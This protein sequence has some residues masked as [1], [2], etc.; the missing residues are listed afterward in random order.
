MGKYDQ[1][2]KGESVIREGRANLQTDFIVPLGGK[3]VLTNIRLMFIPDKFTTVRQEPSGPV[4]IDIADIGEVVKKSGDLGNLLAG[5]FR[6]RL[7]I[8]CRDRSL[9]FQV[10]DINAW[11]ISIKE[12]I[13]NVHT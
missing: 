5:S 8:R 1:L 9:V 13:A 10:W 4:S 7:H 11:I 2:I 3:L 12:M 6:N